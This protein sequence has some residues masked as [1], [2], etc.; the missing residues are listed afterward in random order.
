MR[1]FLAAAA[2]LIV[3]WLFR[4]LPA[5]LGG[6]TLICA[7]GIFWVTNEPCSRRRKASTISWALAI[8][9]AGFFSSSFI[10]RSDRPAGTWALTCAAGGGSVSATSISV[11]TVSFPWNGKRPVHMR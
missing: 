10:T 8:R 5:L 2:A 1:L 6:G 9:L 3:F 11:E 7:L 4:A